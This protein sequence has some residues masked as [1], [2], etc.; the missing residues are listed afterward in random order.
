MRS[1]DSFFTVADVPSVDEA[2][3]WLPQSRAP[4]RRILLLS[5]IH[6]NWHALTEVL[7]HVRGQGC[8]ATWFL[9][10]I[11]GYG[12]RPVECVGLLSR[13]LSRRGRWVAGNHDL[14]ITRQ[15]INMPEMQGTRNSADATNTW[16]IHQQLLEQQPLLWAW[17]RAHA[18][19]A[20]ARLIRRRYGSTWLAFV[21]SNPVDK[22]AYYLYPDDLLNIRTHLRMLPD[23]TV[24]AVGH[25]H[26]VFLAHLPVGDGR[27]RLLPVTYGT[28]ITLGDGAY[29]MNPGSVG[30]PRDGDRRAAYAVLDVAERTVT[31]HRVAY[32]ILA[33]T[34]ELRAAEYPESLVER[35]G[36]GRV[37]HTSNYERV[38]R[39][40]EDG[41]GII[42]VTPS[43]E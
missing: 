30:Q 16:R 21:H 19:H 26:M 6:A 13:G 40:L 10:D 41:S 27:V 28:P 24:L 35:I 25:I 32:D 22:V 14:G 8:N 5:D 36:S 4:V 31:F 7:R 20:R 2:L 23:R 1:F 34:K 29:V 9:G 37:W 39:R 33:V 42:P 43:I 3:T 17:L 12:P 18:T 15:L 11:V 38:Y